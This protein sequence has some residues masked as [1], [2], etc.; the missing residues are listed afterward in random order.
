MSDK[1]R[2]DEGEANIVIGTVQSLEKRLA[3]KEYK[4]WFEQFNV[5]ATDDREVSQVDFFIQTTNTDT[6]ET[7]ETIVKSIARE[8]RY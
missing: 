2:R 6:T 5:V 8:E 3:K 4:T 7:T 1:P